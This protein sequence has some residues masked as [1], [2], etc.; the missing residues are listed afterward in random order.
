VVQRRLPQRRRAGEQ[1]LL[2]RHCHHDGRHRA[3]AHVPEPGEAVVP[4]RR[5]PRPPPALAL[6]G[7][8][9]RRALPPGGPSPVANDSRVNA[10]GTPP[11]A[12]QWPLYFNGNYGSFWNLTDYGGAAGS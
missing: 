4:R 11:M 1:H 9:R 8:V 5:L 12:W 6:P 3:A 10:A 2:R 7:Q